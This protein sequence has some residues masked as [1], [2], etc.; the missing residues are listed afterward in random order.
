ML[1]VI[2]GFFTD[3][4]GDGSSKRVMGIACI[5]AGIVRIFMRDADAATL[6]VLFGTGTALLGVAAVTKT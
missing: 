1:K 3:P 5:L 4:N 6:A 2:K